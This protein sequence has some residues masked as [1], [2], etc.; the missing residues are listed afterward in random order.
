MAELA[1]Q[2]PDAVMKVSRAAIQRFNRQTKYGN[3]DEKCLL[4]TGRTGRGGYGRFDLD[5]GTSIAVHRFVWQYVMGRDIPE[6]MQVDHMCHGSAVAAGT[7]AGAGDEGCRH[8]NCCNPQHLE[9]VTAS[10]NTTRQDHAGRRKTHCPAGHP[11]SED[12]TFV[13]AGRR[14]CKAC[15]QARDRKRKRRDSNAT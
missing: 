11:Y 8:R 12:N 5:D 6:G 15:E 7:C 13:R 4:W 2:M 14:V 9:L 1:V 3:G 10:E